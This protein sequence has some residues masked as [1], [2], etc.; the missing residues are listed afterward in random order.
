MPTSAEAAAPTVTITPPSGTQTAAFDVTITFSEDVTGFEKGDIGLTNGA[1]VMDLTGSDDSYTATIKSKVTG[2]IT[3]SVGANV[4]TNTGGEGN[5]AATNQT[6]SVDLPH[7][8]M[9]MGPS[10]D[11]DRNAAFDIT[12]MFTE[13]VGA[14]VA[15]DITLTPSTM[16]TVGTPSGNAPTYTVTITPAANQDGTLSIQIAAN[17]VQDSSSVN[18]GTASNTVTVD[19]DNVR[20]TVSS[21]TGPS[22]TQNGD[23]A[24]T[25]TFNEEVDDFDAGDLTVSGGASAPSSWTTGADGSTSFTGTIDISGVSTGNSNSVGISVGSN[26]AEDAAGNGN[27]ASA[28]TVD[29]TVTVDNKKPTPT[30]GSVTGTKN[31]DFTVSITFDESVSN[32][33]KSDISFSA[34]SGTAGGTAKSLTGS[35]MTYSATITPSGTGTLRIS[36]PAGAADDG[37][38]NTSNASA[39]VDVSVDTEAPTPTITVP[40]TP[41]NGAFDATIDFGETVTGFVKADVTVGGTATHTVGALSGGTNGSYTLRITPTTSGTITIDVAAN[42]ATDGGSNSN[43]A[44]TQATVTIDKDPPMP[45]ITAPTTDQ[46]DAFDLTIDFGED[47]TGFVVGDLTVAGATKASNW[48]SGDAGPQ[49]YTITLTPTAADGTEGTVTIDVN[50]NVAM[51]AATN[52]NTAATQASVSI[53]KKRPTVM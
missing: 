31:A 50:A 26:V 8:I 42:V 19:I 38:G 24:V 3:I 1:S 39:H 49:T 34:Q 35:G 27:A 13:S 51:D 46:K 29:L 15:G 2:D 22:T 45:T 43:N 44:A 36:V 32:F 11:E 41:Q 9:I 14:F 48:K 16:A 21:I 30:L 53:D 28:S 12:V 4:A 23:F 52:N 40:M 18:Y 6:V 33:A 20:P 47:V 10:G 7:S 25:I 17:A 37:A 5:T